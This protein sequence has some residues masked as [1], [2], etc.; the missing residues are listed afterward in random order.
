[1]CGI[2]GAVSIK[3]QTDLRSNVVAMQEALLH[4]G[5][6]SGGDFFDGELGMAM[7]RLAIIDL[8]T[9][10]QPITNS[11]GNIIVVLNGEIYNY[12]QLTAELLE[13]GYVFK[14]KSDT[15]VIAHGFEEFGLELF[16][17]LEGMFALAVYDRQRKILTLA[18]DRFGE[19]PLYYNSRSD[20]LVFSSEIKSLLTWNDI[21]RKTNREALGYFLRLG[22]VPGTLTMFEGIQ[23]VPVGSI[24]Q[25]SEGRLKLSS[26]YEPNYEVLSDLD[27][28]VEAISAVREALENAVRSQIVSDVPIGAFLSGGIDSS[29]IVAILQGL[30]SQPIKT[31]TVKFEDAKYDESVVARAVANHLGTDHTEIP[32]HNVGFK[33]D[34]LWRIV[35]HV[36]G[37]FADS[38]AIPTYAI[39]KEVSKHVKVCL[40]G[41]GGDEMFA[42]YDV[43][44]QGRRLNQLALIPSPILKGAGLAL[45]AMQ[46]SSKLSGINLIRKTRRAV[47]AA[48]Q[49]PALRFPTMLS[50][51]SAEEA[52]RLIIDPE[53]RSVTQGTLDRVSALPKSSENWTPLRRHMYH[54]LRH[55]LPQDMLIKIDRMSMA[56]S[57][58]LRAPMLDPNLASLTMS[59]QDR[60][61]IRG[62]TRKFAL[63]EAVRPL[64]PEI[65]FRQPKS[66]F[67]IPLHKFQNDEYAELSQEL[68]RKTAGPMSLLNPAA[69]QAIR[70]TG[71]ATEKD[72]ATTSVYRSSHQ[73]W[74]LV[75]LAAW[76]ERFN[77]T[78]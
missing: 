15:E 64:L 37:P 6:D 51:F 8:E 27:S 43:F 38:S 71:L 56:S 54:R 5:P 19:K 52:R 23:E 67:S 46:R 63:R 34:D 41:D 21:P 13:K 10:N 75:Q 16:P 44:P 73:L 30:S 58:E 28:D 68:L 40:T 4:R 48:G 26:Y 45:G 65:V 39:S 57:L 76:A 55:D 77:V 3:S 50:L 53:L 29:A 60:F 70:Q 22:Y 74:A 31:F 33:A 32:V 17:K 59:L 7:R 12:R 69:I 49:P 62:K 9:G 20:S 35:D 42:G 14:T 11:S 47:D 36:G 25:W 72:S 66:G 2:C 61:L 18:R 1:M 78:A 24:L